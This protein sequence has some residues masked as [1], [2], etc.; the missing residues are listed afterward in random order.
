M[1]EIETNDKNF[2]KD[3]IE[4][5]NEIPVLVDFWASWCGPC[6]SLKP[7]LEKLA[8]KNNKKFILAKISVEENQ[9]TAK[10]FE[11][12]SIPAIKFFKKGKIVDE[13]VGAK[14]EEDVKEFLDKNL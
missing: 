9:D 12:M 8:K 13:F 2:Q 4:K 14:S 1:V 3:V 10:K 6:K 11:V 7:I 5:S